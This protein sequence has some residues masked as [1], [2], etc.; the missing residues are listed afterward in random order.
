M[1]VLLLCNT[2][3]SSFNPIQFN[4]AQFGSVRFRSVKE[5]FSLGM[6]ASIQSI[7]SIKIHLSLKANSSRPSSCISIQSTSISSISIYLILFDFY[8]FTIYLPYSTTK[9]NKT[10]HQ[11]TFTARLPPFFVFS[12]I[13]S[14]EMR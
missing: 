6:H 10:K 14:A 8:K 2:R 7:S 13:C 3:R 1:L 12:F 11:I 4:H 5:R 9:Q